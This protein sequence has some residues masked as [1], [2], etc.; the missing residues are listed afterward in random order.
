MPSALEAGTLHYERFFQ[1][2]EDLLCVVDSAG[3]FVC[4]NAAF[5][6]VLGYP[7]QT[8]VG[9]PFAALVHAEDAA[10]VLAFLEGRERGDQGG[11]GV[12]EDVPLRVNARFIHRDRTDRRV[13]LSLRRVAE[14]GEAFFYGAGREVVE[15]E[16]EE[17]RRGRAAVLQKMQATARVGGWEVDVRS[18]S[19]YWTDETYRLHEVPPGFKPVIET[20]IAFYAPESVPI[21]TAAVEGCMKG[22][23]FD[24]ELQL[25][26]ATGRRLWVRAAGEPVIEDG[27]VVR[28]IGSFQDIDD[29]KRREIEL[30]EKLAI[31][32]EQRSAIHA[33]SAPI[34]EVW[35][36]VL[37]LPVVGKLD[38]ARAAE[39]TGRILSAVVAKSASYAILDLTGVEAV[40]EATA[41]HVVRI[42]GAVQLLGAQCI[43]TGVRPAV[44]QTLTDLGSGFGGARTARNLR[45]AIKICMA[46]S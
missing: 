20:A 8:L 31:I 10:P 19:L 41:D 33:M 34:I 28:V 26:T 45:E 36:G 22:Q 6:D 2:S 5:R 35:D 32:K 21:I 9:Q 7:E 12:R 43:V 25:L 39:M 17:Q 42:L 1:T 30:T 18:G 13:S 3:R 24:L 46:A 15:Q 16:S 11:G 44:A 40:D 37:A 23:A 29:F 14:G 38:A 27:Q 4:A